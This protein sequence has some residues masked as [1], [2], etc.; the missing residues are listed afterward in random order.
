MSVATLAASGT[1]QDAMKLF[2]DSLD[3]H[4]ERIAATKRKI[5]ATYSFET[6]EVPYFEYA[7]TG[8]NTDVRQDL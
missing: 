7:I 3:R 2:S 8:S 1:K 6:P 4:G 5:D